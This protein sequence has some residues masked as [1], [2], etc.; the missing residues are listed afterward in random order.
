MRSVLLTI[1]MTLISPMVL[2]HTKVISSV[3]T[4]GSVHNSVLSQIDIEFDEPFIL[5]VI[6]LTDATT[7]FD[8]RYRNQNFN[9]K[10]VH[11]V[12]IEPLPVGQFTLEWRGL[13]KDGHVIKGEFE[14]SVSN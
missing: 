2:A 6:R 12:A 10:N 1:I 5:T 13:A 3:P 11:Q 8:E 7:G 14:F 4:A 9:R